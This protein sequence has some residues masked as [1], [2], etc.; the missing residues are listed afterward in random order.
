MVR[1]VNFK[2]IIERINSLEIDNF[3]QQYMLDN[4]IKIEKLYNIIQNV[5]ETINNIDFKSNIELIKSLNI[6]DTIF[7]IDTFDIESFN[8][9]LD[10]FKNKCVENIKYYQ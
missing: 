9:T 10:S 7:H 5:Q 1:D 3:S 8:H 4:Q 6:K 2:E